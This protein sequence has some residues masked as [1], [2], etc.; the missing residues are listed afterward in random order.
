LPAVL[1]AVITTLEVEDPVLVG[2]SLGGMVSLQ[3]T[4]D[5]PNDLSALIL[6]DTSPTARVMPSFGFLPTI[7]HYWFPDPRRFLPL[8]KSHTFFLEGVLSFINKLKY[9]RRGVAALLVHLLATGKNPDRNLV[10]WC[11]QVLLKDLNIKALLQIMV[12][13]MEFDVINR[14]EEITTPTLIIH[15]SYDRMLSTD[16]ALLLYQTIR[17][18]T[19]HVIEDAGHCPHLEKPR[20]F[21]NTILDFLNQ[22]DRISVLKP[23]VVLSQH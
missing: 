16:L 11:T 19:L 2:W 12:T 9:S 10:S 13:M 14:L 6:V 18:S 5:H 4:L 21:N 22:L 3:Y 17:T 1:D 8:V 15:G 7:P 20:E 23:E